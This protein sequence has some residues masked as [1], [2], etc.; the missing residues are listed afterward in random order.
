MRLGKYAA[1]GLLSFAAACAT[2]PQE[3]AE[4]PAPLPAAPA[5]PVYVLSDILGANVATVD[6]M[7]GKPALTRKEGAGEYRRYALTTCT[8]I[9]ILYPDNLGSSKVEHV[10][11][12]A[13]HSTGDKPDLNACLAAG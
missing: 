7:F 11:A 9:V 13:T 5:E 4:A 3:K 2:A 10:D 6:A 8:L 1:F 12:T